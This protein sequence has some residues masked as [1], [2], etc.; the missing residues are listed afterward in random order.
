MDPDSTPS[1]PGL[2]RLPPE[3]RQMIYQ[4]VFDEQI[5]HVKRFY[6]RW[7]Q[8]Y[9]FWTDL[10]P[11]LLGICRYIRTEASVFLYANKRFMLELGHNPIFGINV[12][13]ERFGRSNTDLIQKNSL[14]LGSQ[15]LSIWGTRGT[16]SLEQVETWVRK[17][18]Q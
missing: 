3:I 6:C 10:R 15:D 17:F 8:K 7:D 1:K 9:M 12:F 13:V 4:E 18:P 11:G 14:N 5:I 16:L 2:L